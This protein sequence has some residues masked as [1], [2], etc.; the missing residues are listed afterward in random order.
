MICFDTINF[1]FL[2]DNDPRATS[3]GVYNFELIRFAG[4]SS[5]SVT[6]ING[7]KL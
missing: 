4:A 7:I 1:P 6:C 5:Q 3:Y 2:D